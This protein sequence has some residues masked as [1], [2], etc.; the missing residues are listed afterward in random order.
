MTPELRIA[1]FLRLGIS[2][3]ARIAHGLGLSVNTVY[4]Y[5]NRLRGRA[6][7]RDSFERDLRE[8]R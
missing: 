5:R 7:D 3:S 2:D 6:V 1:A 4:T 8:I